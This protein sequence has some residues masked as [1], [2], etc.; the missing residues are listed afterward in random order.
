M[1]NTNLKNKDKSVSGK[2]S[3]RK[4]MIL[5]FLRGSKRWF[6]FAVMSAWVVSLLDLINP[7]IIGFTVDSVIDADAVTIPRW[8]SFFVNTAGGLAVLRKHL[9]ILALLVAC[10]ALVRALFRYLFEL[11]NT[12][13]AERLVKTMRDDLF[14]HIIR[15]P[16]E[17]HNENSTGD[18]IQRCTSDVDTVK[19]FLSE[20]LTALLRTIILMVLSLVFMF[21]IH[22]GLAAAAAVFI[23]VIILY[24]VC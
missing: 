3:T 22:T 14:A 19:V 18:I 16:Y 15:L 6:V 21:R 8:I 13:G 1:R 10:F 17:W 4:G 24:S 23:P 5:Y 20:Q 11:F 12:R 7:K 9:W 2:F